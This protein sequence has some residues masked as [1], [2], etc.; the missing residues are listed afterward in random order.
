[1]PMNPLIYFTIAMVAVPAGAQVSPSPPILTELSKC[2][3]LT[4]ND[5]R[6]RCYDAAAD[7]LARA[8]SSGSLI[9]VDKDDLRR[10]R[11]SLFGLSLPKLPF[12]T[13][14]RSGEDEV[15]EI[16]KSARVGRDDK[17]LVELESGGTWQTTETETRQSPPKAG[18]S[19]KIRRASLGGFMLSVEGRRSV[20][21]MRLR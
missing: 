18:D 3:N 20:R 11:R 13:G 1:M 2:R 21:A 10:T 14:D 8:T 19:I 15:D 6:L 9:V 5:A 16:V 7:A 17:W 12:F 4:Q